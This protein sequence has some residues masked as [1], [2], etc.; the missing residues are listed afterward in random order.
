[1]SEKLKFLSYDPLLKENAREN[2][3][4]PSPAEKK[5]WNEVL[6]GKSFHDLKF[7]RQKPLDRYIVDFYCSELKLVI[8][9]DG[10]SHGDQEI[11]DAD[12]TRKLNEIGVTVIRYMNE[13]VMKNPEGVYK[14]LSEKI[15]TLKEAGG[16]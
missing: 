13:D 15:H 10:H 16:R 8:E 2:R 4:N 9:I 11:Y 1:M 7:T 6:R 5:M 3:H 12:R 14:D